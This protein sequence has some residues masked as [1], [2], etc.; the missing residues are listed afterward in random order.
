MLKHNYTRV[1]AYFQVCKE[2]KKKRDSKKKNDILYNNLGK[3]P[4][5]WV[6]NDYIW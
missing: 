6:K 3:T 2:T 5:F 1:C 4:L